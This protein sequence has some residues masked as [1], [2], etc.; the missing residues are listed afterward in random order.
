VQ[1]GTFLDLSST[2]VLTQNIGCANNLTITDASSG[3][4]LNGS[5]YSLSIGG[6]MSL[7]SG[8]GLYLSS[9]VGGDLYVGGN[10]VHTGGTFAP[11]G[12]AV[13][14]TGSV[15]DTL[16]ATGGEN[17]AYLFINKAHSSN[18]LLLANNITV[19][20]V[21]NLDS[22]IINTA[23]DT[24]IISGTAS[25]AIT[26]Q[27]TGSYINGYLQRAVTTGSYDF[28][29]GTATAYELA[30]IN[31]T[32]QS[33]MSNI[34]G[35]FTAG[36]P[37]TGPSA[38]TCSINGTPIPNMLNGGYWTLTPDAYSSV[39][40]DVTLHESGY[41]TA[42]RNSDSTGV[43]KRHDASSAWAGTDLAGTN[44]YHSNAN[45]TISN[46]VASVKRTGVTSFSDFGIGVSGTY[47]LPVQMVYFTA[48]K[49]GE[50][51]LLGWATATEINNDH[52][53]VERSTDGVSFEKIGQV[54]GHGNSVEMITYAY[55]DESLTEVNASV[56]YYRLKQV[57]IDG[58]Y[59]YSTIAALNIGNNA[60]PLHIISSYPNPFSDH[61]S[62]SVY[63]P[64]AQTARVSIYDVRGAL[65]REE[66]TSLAAG[67]NVYGMANTSQL[68]DG[69]YTMNMSVGQMNYSIKLVKGE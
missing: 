19:A 69:F 35:Y 56:V 66:N 22:G 17:F 20:N 53:D 59:E 63:S 40:Y 54:A 24:V 23:T 2:N 32:S 39:L 27:N 67:F 46:G 61:L 45:S 33:G 25:S 37:A 28:P 18:T 16:T 13:F 43:I 6:N 65:V 36:L 9:A 12:R 51:A 55:T 62:I 38:S 60:Q 34:K 44:G 52:F 31:L 10:W 42:V 4:G 50:N 8:N 15:N 48:D 26:G 41:S 64:S 58:K 29:L 68:A 7:L 47:A 30:N 21:L 57:D 14:F 1:N 49:S 11:N 3:V 5:V